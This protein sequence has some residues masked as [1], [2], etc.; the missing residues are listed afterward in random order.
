MGLEVP[1]EAGAEV[2]LQDGQIQLR[3][4][5]VTASGMSLPEVAL[6]IVD[7]LV[8]AV[9]VARMPPLPFGITLDALVVTPDG[10]AITATGRGVTLAT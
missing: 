6:P 4:R 8:N 9:I 2:A 10:L 5:D 3:F 7:T 1:I